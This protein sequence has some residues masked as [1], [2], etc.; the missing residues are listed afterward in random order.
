MEVEK[1]NVFD[2]YDK[3]AGEFSD[4]RSYKWS[5]VR[6]FIANCE[7]NRVFADI[8]CGN[9]KNVIGIESPAIFCLDTCL[10][11]LDITK[12]RGFESM[13]A[14]MT[15]LP[16][17]D[18]SID[19]ILCVA[20]FHHLASVE[21]RLIALRELKRVLAPNGKIFLTVW[22][23]EQPKKTRRVFPDYGDTFV[24]WKNDNPRYYYIFKIDEIKELFKE[25]G[26]NIERH[27]WDC[28]NEIF[29]L[30]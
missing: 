7:K 22:S 17:R 21:R 26:L 4:S 20:A 9:G 15:S 14:S 18:S 19:Y 25:S 16:Y 13:T 28:G 12:S 5:S 10:P 8:G 2:I 6:D 1:T 24:E 27:Y 29:I 11:F 3:I 30:N 23:K